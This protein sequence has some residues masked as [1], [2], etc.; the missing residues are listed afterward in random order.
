MGT[1]IKPTTNLKR[2]S[3]GAFSVAALVQKRVSGAWA[4]ATFVKRRTGGAWVFVYSTPDVSVSGGGA[5]TNSGASTGGTTSVG[6]SST[7]GGVNSGSLSYSWSYVSGD[8]AISVNNAALQNPTFSRTFSGVPNGTTSS[9]V[10]AVW[11]CTLTDTITGAQVYADLSIGPLAWQNT[12]P[13]FTPHTDTFQNGQSGSIAVPTGA[14]HLQMIAEGGGGVGGAWDGS[15]TGGGGGGGSRV[16]SDY[17]IVSGDWGTNLSYVSGG[18]SGG[19]GDA[20][21]ITGTISAGSFN[22]IAG[23]GFQAGSALS[24]GAGGNAS[25][26]NTANN[27]G[28]GGSGG[29]GGTSANGSSGGAPGCPGNSGTDPGGGGGGDSCGS[30]NGSGGYGRVRFIW[31]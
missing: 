28:G 23:G 22:L 20:S 19:N 12:I 4:N 31:T 17:T 13:A 5:A 2:R 6:G 26:G 18:V 27:N 16:I 8:G 29:T 11:R 15:N 9:G 24:D 3:S 10:S 14:S 25:G 1:L 21:S 30:G 7:P